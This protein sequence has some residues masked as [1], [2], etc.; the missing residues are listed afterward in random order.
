MQ[1][2][3]YGQSIRESQKSGPN[4]PNSVKVVQEEL[5]AL[6]KEQ[7]A[8][9]RKEVEELKKECNT[10]REQHAHANKE[11][12]DEVRKQTADTIIDGSKKHF[13]LQRRAAAKETAGM[14]EKWTSQKKAN[15]AEFLAA[16]K[17]R[18]A[19]SASSRDASRSARQGLQAKRME[20]AALM[21]E[22]RATLTEQRQL[23]LTEQSMLV[24]ETVNNTIS[25]RFVHPEASRRM[26][27]HPHYSEVSAVVTDVTSSVSREIASSPR[28]SRRPNSAPGPATPA[29]KG[30]AAPKS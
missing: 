29:I 28:R 23:N 15:R 10:L 19:K 8:E 16:F 22:Q 4:G 13:F 24:R 30:A 6:K 27:T 20:E 2:A 14:V 1:W 18:A 12:A 21:R 7:G 26:I 9:V 3:K 25:E 17:A 11:K 5:T